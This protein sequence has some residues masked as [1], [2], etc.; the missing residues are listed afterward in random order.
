MKGDTI[1]RNIE[2]MTTTL[3][4]ALSLYAYTSSSKEITLYAMIG[5]Q[6]DD[7]ENAVCC[8]WIPADNNL[9][10]IRLSKATVADSII[11]GYISR[12]DVH[13]KLLLSDTVRKIE[14]WES[15]ETTAMIND[16]LY[17]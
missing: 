4:N 13:M 5:E 12:C 15:E 10:I 3:Y 7:T 9:L 11:I 16:F 17:E 8:R 1:E 14:A 2:I 6:P